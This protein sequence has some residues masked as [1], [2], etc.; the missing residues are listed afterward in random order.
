MG[1]KKRNQEFGRLGVWVWRMGGEEKE[2]IKVFRPKNHFIMSVSDVVARAK[3]AWLE[4]RKEAPRISENRAV[5]SSEEKF[6]RASMLL[7]QK[8]KIQ[9][10][11]TLLCGLRLGSFLCSN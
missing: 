6:T 11:I 8:L 4:R 1:K 9:I 7:A 5:R 2:K 10:G 3:E